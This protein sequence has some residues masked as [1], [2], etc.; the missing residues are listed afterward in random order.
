MIYSSN[1]TNLTGNFTTS[2]SGILVNY[3]GIGVSWS[4]NVI[5]I[6]NDIS[7]FCELALMALGYDISFED[8][9]KMSKEERKSIIRDI[10]INRIFERE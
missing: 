3:T 1:S 2:T 8:F 7:E 9:Q 10:K 5:S 6:N 4:N